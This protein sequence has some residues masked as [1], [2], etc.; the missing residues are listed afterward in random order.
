M[1]F[2]EKKRDTLE[3]E[4]VLLDP[5]KVLILLSYCS[6]CNL[7][8]YV[9]VVLP[10]PLFSSLLFSLVSILWC[11]RRSVGEQ[12]VALAAV[13]CHSS[14]SFRIFKPRQRREATL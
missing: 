3:L 9:V 8:Y 5:P 14:S 11:R 1:I 7:L 10:N 2:E 6:L 12:L 13:A 4:I